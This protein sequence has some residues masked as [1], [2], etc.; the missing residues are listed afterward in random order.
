MLTVVFDAGPLITACKFKTQGKLVV[1]HLLDE[2][3]III[4]PAVEEEVAVLGARYPDGMAAGERIAKGE[5]QVVSVTKRRWTR[6]LADYA[7]GEG[8]RDSIE[9]CGQTEAE[10]LVTDD[11]LAFVVTTR[12]GLK[13]WMLPD[14]VIKLAECKGLTIEVANSV[15]EI[16][17]P[18]YRA[19]M[20]EHSLVSLQEVKENAESCGAGEGGN[21]AGGGTP[22]GSGNG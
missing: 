2:C 22:Q 16:I 19:G 15:M 4:P 1:D 3:R 20:I 21:S 10:V 5:I 7:L 18:R 8:E 12:L 13:A 6:H 17:R 14:L 11:Y 9:L